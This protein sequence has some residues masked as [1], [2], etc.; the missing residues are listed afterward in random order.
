MEEGSFKNYMLLIRVGLALVGLLILSIVVVYGQLFVSKQL[1]EAGW[2]GA[3]HFIAWAVLVWWTVLG[4]FVQAGQKLFEWMAPETR[5]FVA[6]KGLTAGAV[7]LFLIP[8][9]F[10][11]FLTTWTGDQ[12]AFQ[13]LEIVYVLEGGAPFF[14]WFMIMGFNS[15]HGAERLMLLLGRWGS[16]AL[17]ANA[18]VWAAGWHV[19]AGLQPEF[20][21][22]V[23]VFGALFGYTASTFEEAHSGELPEH[24]REAAS[25]LPRLGWMVHLSAPAVAFG[26]LLTSLAL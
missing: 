7:G 26:P 19:P 1:V 2:T 6:A 16:L 18:V 13:R 25:K 12:A 21:A 17:L 22:Y 23:S 20:G 10:A 14:L 9:S 3:A 24:L 4:L 15:S 8:S 5:R 11:G